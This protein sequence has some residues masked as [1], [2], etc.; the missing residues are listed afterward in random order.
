VDFVRLSVFDTAFGCDYVVGW[1]VNGKMNL[2]GF[3][4][5]KIHASNEEYGVLT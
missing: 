1:S 5:S 2:D 4:E 3:M